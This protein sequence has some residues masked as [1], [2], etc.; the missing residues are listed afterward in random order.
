MVDNHELRKISIISNLP[1]DKLE[2]LG[3]V[4]ELKIFSD[5]TTLFNQGE[6]LDHCYMILSG[7]VLLEVHPA[8]DIIITLNNL[9]PGTCFAL[10]SLI[11]GSIS[12]NSAVCAQSC[13]LLVLPADKLHE[14]F[15]EQHELGYQFM[16]R[17]MRIFKE[18]MDHRTQLFLRALK[19]HPELEHLFSNQ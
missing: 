19:N 1:D 3:K 11:P 12:Q 18:R 9:E 7:T 4:G 2:M 14:L 15:S 8:E 17:I 13:E 10:S 16:Y 5:G 6:V